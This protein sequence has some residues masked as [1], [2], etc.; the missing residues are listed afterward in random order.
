MAATMSAPVPAPSA[1]SDHDQFAG[2][3]VRVGWAARI[4]I[5]APVIAVFAAIVGIPLYA[6]PLSDAALTS[7]FALT[8][9]GA[10]L[11]LIAL[12][13]GLIAIYLAG[14]HRMTAVGHAGFA[15]ALAGTVLAAGGAWDSLF[16]VPYLAERAP[17]VL[18]AGTSGSLLAGYVIS[19]LVLVI[20]WA[21]LATTILRRRMLPR[22]VPAALLAGA[23][24]AII[25]APTPLRLLPLALGAALACRAVLRADP[26]RPTRR[27]PPEGA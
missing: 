11:V 5:A 17:D 6:D 15:I 27:R 3:G 7:R 23:I 20:G 16:T 18:T 12:V 8:A 21:V 14:V 25:P 22:S 4:G 13:F 1:S 24:L 26:Q 19:Y 9:A 10:L 2:N